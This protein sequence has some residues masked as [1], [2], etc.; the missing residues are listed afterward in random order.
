MKLYMGVIPVLLPG[1][2]E[3]ISPQMAIKL[4]IWVIIGTNCTCRFLSNQ[5]KNTSFISN[6]TI[7]DGGISLDCQFLIAPLVFFNIDLY[8]KRGQNSEI[9]HICKVHVYRTFIF[10]HF[11]CAFSL[12]WL[13]KSFVGMATDFR[14]LVLWY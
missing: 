11:W 14:H 12:N 1:F 4:T 3:C 2:M 8:C 10:D 5:I 7:Q 6:I 13:V 9:S